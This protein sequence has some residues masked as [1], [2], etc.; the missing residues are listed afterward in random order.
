MAVPLGM[1]RFWPE[2]ERTDVD[3]GPGHLAERGGASGWRM[4]TREEVTNLTDW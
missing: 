4:K 3:P 2:F 1:S